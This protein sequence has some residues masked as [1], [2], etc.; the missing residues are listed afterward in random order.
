MPLRRGWVHS[1]RRPA[2][3]SARLRGGGRTCRRGPACETREPRGR[4]FPG[5][6]GR[7]S[8]PCRVVR[9]RPGRWCGL[10][11]GASLPTGRTARPLRPFGQAWRTEACRPLGA[12]NVSRRRTPAQRPPAPPAPYRT[13]GAGVGGVRGGGG[14][15]GAARAPGEARGHHTKGEPRAS[16]A[17]PGSTGNRAATK[18]PGTTSHGEAPPRPAAARSLGP[19]PDEKNPPRL[20]CPLFR[21]SLF[22]LPLETRPEPPARM[23]FPPRQPARFTL[24]PLGW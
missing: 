21:T 10:G 1:G 8:V 18:R 11:G 12:G 22:L 5:A 20:D 6:A 4:A 15:R 13:R 19:H 2:R 16:A 17:A 24:R 9:C 23:R 7:W 3:R 14:R